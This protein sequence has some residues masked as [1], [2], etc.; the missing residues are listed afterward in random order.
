M[1][2]LSSAENVYRYDISCGEEMVGCGREQGK[3]LWAGL[4]REVLLCVKPIQIGL[5][6][7]LE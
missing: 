6:R 7:E 5:G 3:C 2:G 4:G 1:E